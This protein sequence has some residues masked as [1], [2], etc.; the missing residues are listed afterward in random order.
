M[1]PVDPRNSFHL[2]LISTPV[3]PAI[4]LVADMAEMGIA[5]L[6]LNPTHV[7]FCICLQ[8]LHTRYYTSFVTPIRCC[9]LPLIAQSARME[10]AL[11]ASAPT[12]HTARIVASCSSKA[13]TSYASS[14]SKYRLTSQTQ[15]QRARL[16]PCQ[17]AA[18]ASGGDEPE[19]KKWT[20]SS[21]LS[22][23][24]NNGKGEGSDKP[25]PIPRKKS[26]W[27]EDWEADW[28]PQAGLSQEQME[29]EEYEAYRALRRPSKGDA[30]RDKWITPLLDFQAIAE[31]FDPDQERTEQSLQD[32]ALTNKEVR[33]PAG[34]I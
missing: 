4:A 21:L 12:Q 16:S 30:P 15:Q 24:K 27:E 19:F 17:A 1:E 6:V 23:K 2:V 33:I 5:L 11:R 26:D 31:A 7:S 13:S 18:D 29:M 34:V 14:L 3:A 25:T 8:L 9:R 10:T 28:D 20:L 32:E 22:R